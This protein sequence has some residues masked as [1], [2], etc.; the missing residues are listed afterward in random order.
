MTTELTPLKGDIVPADNIARWTAVQTIINQ[1]VPPSVVK[2]RPGRGGKTFSYVSHDW[3][4]KT[5]NDAF[6]FDWD[7]EPM[8]Q[9]LQWE[10]DGVG[11][12]CRLT[13]RVG[14][15]IIS[16]IEY[17]WKETIQNREGNRA[18]GTGDQIKSAISDGLRRCAMRLG[19]GLSLYGGED[20]MTANEI[21]T[22]LSSYAKTHLGWDPRR[23]FDWLK[24]QGYVEADL[25]PKRDA[26]YEALAR[27]AGKAGVTEDFDEPEPPAPK[28]RTDLTGVGKSVDGLRA[29]GEAKMREQPTVPDEPPEGLDDLIEQVE[30]LTAPHWI[31]DPKSRARWE[32]WLKKHGWTHETAKAALKVESIRDYH[33]NQGEAQTALYQLKPPE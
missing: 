1:V 28:P 15:K 4:T 23:T 21:K 16:K 24:E 2:T 13:V 14:Q 27:E 7:F 32:A 20:E 12:F 5:L 29:I 19:L 33:G 18:M 22:M 9:T 30:K 31:D 26:M 6:G 17:G 25:L 11:L 10:T 8:P 3:V